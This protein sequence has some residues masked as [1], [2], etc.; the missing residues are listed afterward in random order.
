MTLYIRITA[1]AVVVLLVCGTPARAQTLPGT[2]KVSAPAASAMAQRSGPGAQVPAGTQPIGPPAR[3]GVGLTETRLTLQEAVEMAIRN[4]L[5]VDIERTNVATSVQ[6]TRAARGAFD[7]VLQFRP[8]W[9]DATTPASSAL[10]AADGR[11][12][13][14]SFGSNFRFVQPLTAFG[15]RFNADFENLRIATNNPFTNLNPY[16]NSR[17]LFGVQQPLLRGFLTDPLRT[18]VKVRTRAAAISETSL[19]LAVIDVVARVEQAY[20]DLVS[21]RQD[22][23]V[24]RESAELARQQLEMNRRMVAAG[25][26]ARVELFA[27]EAELQRRLDTLYTSVG[28]VTTAENRLKTLLSPDPEHSI[29]NDVIVPA[30]A[31][32]PTTLGEIVDVHE[33]SAQALRERLELEA[34]RGQSEIAK[35][36]RELA[37]NQRLPQVDIVAGYANSGLAGTLLQRENPFTAL[38][39]QIV[40]RLNI[41]SQQTGLQPLPAPSLGRF[42]P[43]LI[44]GYGGALDN[45]FSRSFPT[46]QVGLSLD[47]NF[48]N[49]TAEANLAQAQIAERR[50]GLQRKQIQQLIQ[51]Q[52]R[53][54]V[55]GIVTAR[56]RVAAAEASTRAAREQLESETRLFQAGESTNFLVLTRQ[57]EYAESRLREVLANL[58]LN[59]SASRLEQALGATLR[60]YNIRLQ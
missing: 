8:T 1:L 32:R 34:N 6:A 49:R 7:P 46:Y 55:Q 41:L 52:V 39:A 20:W 16:F 10:Q 13:S 27:S 53:D 48:R 2:S 17:L 5:E 37:A 43:D 29:W 44:G 45:L 4:N 25:T 28:S 22:V 11:L 56:Q 58:E 19:R 15:T 3:V 47:L 40:D 21:A 31:R 24:Q 38:N 51:Q 26:L 54:A 60:T 30:D 35:L 12:V 57:S 33:L 23:D 59:R 14:R 42:P 36:Q 18:E 9:E 50:L